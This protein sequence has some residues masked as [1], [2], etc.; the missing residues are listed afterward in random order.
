MGV[1]LGGCGQGP[2]QGGPE[3]RD[4]GTNGTGHDVNA[5]EVVLDITAAWFIVCVLM[6]QISVCNMQ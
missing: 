6:V 4:P 1:I 3:T 5:M 2:P